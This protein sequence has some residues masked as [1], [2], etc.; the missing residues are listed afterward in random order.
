MKD[1]HYKSAT[2][3]AQAIRQG[4]LSSR[5]LVQASIERIRQVNP[6][7][8][9]VVQLTAG[10]AMDDAQKADEEW[11]QGSL[12]GPLHG[13]PMTIKDSIDTAGV[14][15][16]WGTVG[17]K[18]HIPGR[19]ATIVSRLKRAGAILLGKTNTPEMTLSFATANRVYG[20]TNNPHD[21][22]RT[23]GGSSGGCALRPAV[24]AWAA[25]APVAAES[26]RAARKVP[27]AAPAESRAAAGAESRPAGAAPPAP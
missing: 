8:N 23:P 25:P 24:I 27:A 4:E 26:L 22:S 2:W 18:G 19:D 6:R 3:M 12:R 21:L 16:T 17:R 11:K 13:V 15:T 20:R 5:E 9:A 14:V 1:L 7:L 10:Q